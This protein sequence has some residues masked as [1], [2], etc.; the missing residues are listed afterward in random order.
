MASLL[1]ACVQLG[2]IWL[3]VILLGPLWAKLAYDWVHF[4]LVKPNVAR[5]KLWFKMRAARKERRKL[6]EIERLKQKL[7]WA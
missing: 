6:K 4:S 7:G 1:T 2:S 3:Y 5:V